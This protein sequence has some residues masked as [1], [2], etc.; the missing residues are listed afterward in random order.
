MMR[1]MFSGVSG[2]RVH[3]TKM[4]VIANNISNVNTMGFKGSRVTFNE[5]FSQTLSGASASNPVTGK[6]GVNPMQVG[7]GVNIASIDKIMTTGAAQRTDRSL[8]LMVQGNGFFIVAD[9]GGTY[10]TRAGA[11]DVDE[12]GYLVT[13]T[14]YKVQ[15]WNADA[16]GTITKGPVQD[17]F[18]GGNKEYLV[19]RATTDVQFTG[20]LNYEESLVNPKISSISFF[21]SVGTKYTMDVQF[22]P[23]AV[24]TNGETKWTM[25]FV[26]DT[27][28]PPKFNMYVDGDRDNPI[29]LTASPSLAVGTGTGA[30]SQELIFGSDGLLKSAGGN[31][32]LPLE[33]NMTFPIGIEALLKPGATLGAATG[34]A[35][36]PIKIGLRTDLKGI[37]QFDEKSTAKADSNGNAPGKLQAISVGPDGKIT[38]RYT[39]SETKYL[40][41]IPVARFANPG[42]LEKIGDNMFVVTPNSGGFDGTGEDVGADG[43]KILGG[44]LEMSNVDLSSEFT[45]MITT[46]RGFQA[47]S[48]IITTSDE[49]L[50]ELV[51]LKR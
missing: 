47:N 48:R 39:N 45:E 34:G 44:V 3:Q 8:D 6:G 9:A 50:Q 42:G 49:M 51:N 27:S 36:G 40:G 20:N 4:D 5:V 31:T 22:V 11:F 10:F 17:I 18:L 13:T 37:T 23:G 24:A 26:S 15:G 1:S 7:L 12:A 38:G 29:S 33:L 30:A 32:T 2:L 25:S 19:P 46:Q 14:G 35:S 21:D 43:S 41:Q 28:T 16:K